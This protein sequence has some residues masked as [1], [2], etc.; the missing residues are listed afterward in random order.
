[1]ERF[2]RRMKIEF[3]RRELDNEI[4]DT[5]G[6]QD[7]DRNAGQRFDQTVETFD[8]DGRK[9]GDP[10]YTAVPPALPGAGAHGGLTMDVLVSS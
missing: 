2:A 3:R 6:S 10:Q 5:L 7:S 8:H 1:M 9:K 4:M